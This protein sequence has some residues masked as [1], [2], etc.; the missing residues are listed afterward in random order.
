MATVDL[1]KVAFTF[2]GT[3]AGGTTYEEK[4]VVAFTDSGELSSYV[5]VNATAT[6]GQAPSSSGT[7][8]TTYWNKIAKGTTL[9]VGNNKIVTTDG[10]GNVSSLAMGSAEQALKVN[11]SANGF[12]FGAIPSDYV[13][14]TS[15][16]FSNVSNVDFAASL[17]VGS[18]YKSFVNMIE[19]Q[20]HDTTRSG[21]GEFRP[22]TDGSNVGSA[23]SSCGIG[24]NSSSSSVGGL[25]RDNAD[26]CV[27]YND[28]VR[29]VRALIKIESN[30]MNRTDCNN[31]HFINNIRPNHDGTTRCRWDFHAVHHNRESATGDGYR[32][33]LN[34]GATGT[35]ILYGRK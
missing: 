14:I 16:T 4:D 22:Q 2:K 20:D 24:M 11:A 10:S 29:N 32:I 17:F 35:Y 5:F 9:S 34:G 6:A 12:E 13:K 8:N 33:Q 18:T 31:N 28:G 23:V 3:Y 1:G 26:S 25:N 27:I 30:G 7:V 21:N 15:G 19:L